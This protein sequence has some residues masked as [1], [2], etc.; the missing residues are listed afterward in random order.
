MHIK[1]QS[2]Y[3]R[4]VLEHFATFVNKP[5]DT[6]CDPGQVL[7][8]DSDDLPA[9]S[10]PYQEVVGSLLYLAT[11]SRPDIAFGVNLVSRFTHEPKECHWKA[12][13][14]ILGYLNRTIT[15]SIV[16]KRGSSLY[17]IAYSDSDFAMCPDTRK[18]T[19]GFVVMMSGGPV[20]WFSQK[21]KLF[22]DQHVLLNM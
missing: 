13:K 10:F 9:S 18:S 11:L 6:P 21:Q 17:P 12:V 15:K 22:V 5:S 7:S 1:N 2:T 16:Y 14:R 20:M 3:T 19:S 4:K 8:K